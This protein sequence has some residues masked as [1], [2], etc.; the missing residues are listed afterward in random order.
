MKRVEAVL[1][2][3]KCYNFALVL[4]ND[5]LLKQERWTANDAIAMADRLSNEV[6]QTVNGFFGKQQKTVSKKALS[7]RN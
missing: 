6:K 1:F 2:N 5:W 3:G 7:R 4:A